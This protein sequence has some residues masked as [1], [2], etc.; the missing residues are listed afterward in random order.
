[1]RIRHR[2]KRL[3]KYGSLSQLLRVV[4]KGQPLGVYNRLTSQATAVARAFLPP[5]NEPRFPSD[6]EKHYRSLGY[7]DQYWRER[8]VANLMEK[9]IQLLK[10]VLPKSQDGAAPKL[11]KDLE[12]R[13]AGQKRT[14]RTALVIA[15]SKYHEDYE[16][17]KEKLIRISP[18][19]AED[20]EREKRLLRLVQHCQFLHQTRQIIPLL[21]VLRIGAVS[22]IPLTCLG[23]LAVV[24]DS[25]MA[26]GAPW[27]I[28]LG[29]PISVMAPMF[30]ASLS[31]ALRNHLSDI[32][33]KQ[34]ERLELIKAYSAVVQGAVHAET[35]PKN[36]I[37]FLQQEIDM[38][39]QRLK[40]A[41]ESTSEIKAQNPFV[42]V[43]GWKEIATGPVPDE[44]E[45]KETANED[46]DE[47]DDAKNK[48]KDGS[49]LRS[50]I[51]ASVCVA[52]VGILLPL[53]FALA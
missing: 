48:E 30:C 3:A 19:F 43:E 13:L 35:Q 41:I 49:S 18:E 22:L 33:H 4:Q 28:L 36:T 5:T 14:S 10:D 50:N 51:F 16:W 8:S 31:D 40:F 1:M 23:S 45:T 42:P 52:L 15:N 25:M 21:S 27:G 7:P 38:I 2:Q 46:A 29:L 26:H 37:W 34:N 11:I 17:V 44:P 47:N 53:R 24:G 20:V 6:V 32:K 39:V 9:E 12:K